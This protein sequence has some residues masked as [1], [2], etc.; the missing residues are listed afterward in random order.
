MIKR[1]FLG[2]VKPKLQYNFVPDPVQDIPPPNSVTLLLKEARNGAAT[3]AF[4]VGDGVKTG[5][6][7]STFGGGPVPCAAALATLEVIDRERLIE[8]AITV[9]A[10]LRAGAIAA[11]VRRVTGRG[12]LLGLHLG[13]P[14]APVQRAL[15]ARRI[16]T[17]TAS[18]PE[19][20]RLLPP[21]TLTR[22]EADLVLTALGEALT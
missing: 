11:G 7:G 3:T 15:F 4:K 22:A 12:L 2:L 10:H 5:D 6:L 18:D 14:A 20:L 8:N 17:G 13:R 9:G 21:L 16:L 19:V 1:S